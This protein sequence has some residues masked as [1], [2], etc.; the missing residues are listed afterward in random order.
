VDG[1]RPDFFDALAQRLRERIRAGEFRP[2]IL[3]PSEAELAGAVGTK[4]YSI[5]KAL[6]LLQAEGIVCSVPGRGWVVLDERMKTCAGGSS[7]TRYRKIADEL[8][9]AIESGQLPAGSVLPSEAEL[10]A[11]HGVSR[12]TV[13]RA[14]DVL[15]SDGLIISHHG[16]GRFVRVG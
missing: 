13:R 9:T 7:V 15:E 2:G 8:R 16:R 10:V 5:R 3:L 11:R 14:L 1:R 4:R 6:A 12:A